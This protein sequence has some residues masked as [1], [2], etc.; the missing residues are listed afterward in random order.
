M[1]I[2][3]EMKVPEF[4]PERQ[5]RPESKVALDM[6]KRGP[7]IPL[8]YITVEM[9]LGGDDYMT[10]TDLLTVVNTLTQNNE[11]LAGLIYELTVEMKQVKLHLASVSDEDIDEKDV[12]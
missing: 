12:D 4:Y 7:S 1:D 9:L 5:G 8:H 10:A 11:I 3:T 6:D 2:R